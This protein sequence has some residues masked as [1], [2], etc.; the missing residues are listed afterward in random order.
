M[1]I[2]TACVSGMRADTPVDMPDEK[3]NKVKITVEQKPTLN[4]QDNTKNCAT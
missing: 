3:C 2:I 1:I 4:M